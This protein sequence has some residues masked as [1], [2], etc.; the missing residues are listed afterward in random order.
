[1]TNSTYRVT[2]T[3]VYFWGSYL[4]QWAWT[5]FTGN[6]PKLN[7]SKTKLMPLEN[8]VWQKFNFESCEQYMMA[9]KA[10]IFNDIDTFNL[11]CAERDPAKCKQ[12]GRKVKNFNDETW[13]KFAKQIVFLGNFYKFTQDVNSIKFLL[14]ECDNKIIVEGSPYD[15]IWGV[16]LKWDDPAIENENNW[17]GTNWLGETIM[18]VRDYLN[19][20]FDNRHNPFD[21]L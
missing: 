17:K 2:Y 16:G 20:G 4:S 19:L 1:M 15:K 8:G 11:I 12:L 5:P 13:Q 10:I 3:H 21:L 18:A 7:F 9:S 14:T 6:F